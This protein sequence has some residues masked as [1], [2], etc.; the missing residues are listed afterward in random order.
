MFELK[1]W[2]P[3]KELSIIQ[4]DMDEFFRRMFGTVRSIGFLKRE[5]PRMPVYPAVDMFM[6]EG[7]LVVHAELPGINPK[8]VDVSV[9]GNVLTI[10]GERK[11]RWEEKKEGCLVTETSYG[12]FERSI[13]LP[14]GVDTTRCTAGYKD[15][16]L[17]LSMPAEAKALP[18]KVRIEVE[19]ETTKEK[20]SKKVA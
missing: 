1:K 13:E 2:D 5:L 18:K 16:I 7:K 19:G 8:D 15:G 10:R 9:T 12:S 20:E 4:R 14:D 6:K 11:A 17:E 3:M